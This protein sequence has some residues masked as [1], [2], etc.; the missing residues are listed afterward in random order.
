M[1]HHHGTPLFSLQFDHFDHDLTLIYKMSTR[2]Y[3]PLIR[4]ND[5]TEMLI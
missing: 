2:D 5:S 4:M 1:F 3:G